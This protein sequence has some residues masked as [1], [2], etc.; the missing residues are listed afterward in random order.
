MLPNVIRG[1]RRSSSSLT[2]VTSATAAPV[3]IQI[4]PSRSTERRVLGLRSERASSMSDA[5]STSSAAPF[6][7]RDTHHIPHTS[8]ELLHVLPLCQHAAVRAGNRYLA[9]TSLLA[10]GQRQI[11]PSVVVAERCP[12]IQ[13]DRQFVVDPV[14]DITENPHPLTKVGWHER[15]GRNGQGNEHPVTNELEFHPACFDVQIVQHLGGPRPARYVVYDSREDEHFLTV[16]RSPQEQHGGSNP[17]RDVTF[18]V[19]ERRMTEHLRQLGL[20]QPVE[21]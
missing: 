18:G 17:D 6:S 3:A 7:E 16:R 12:P 19:T 15:L 5:L 14:C 20:D 8:M 11:S 2:S 9:T 10:E 21:M 1:R 13:L 4:T